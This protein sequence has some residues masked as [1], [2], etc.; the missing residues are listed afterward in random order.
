VSSTITITDLIRAGPTMTLTVGFIGPPG[1]PG[2]QGPS[3]VVQITRT[4]GVALSGHRIVRLNADG[5]AIY[6]DCETL[7]DASVVL[8]MTVGAAEQG[9]SATIQTE[10]E[11][12]EPSWTWNP[13]LP[14][15]LSTAGQLTQTPPASGFVLCVAVPTG[16]DRAVVR[17]GEPILL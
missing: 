17:I 12:V 8:G 4:A 11:L 7:S 3:G 9:A 16:I 13:D 1:P 14:I 10:G 6:A 15:F 5:E 2:P